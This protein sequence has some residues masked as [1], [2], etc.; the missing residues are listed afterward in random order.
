MAEFNNSD[1]YYNNQNKTFDLN[2]RTLRNNNGTFDNRGGTFLGWGDIYSIDGTFNNE[3]GDFDA[4]ETTIGMLGG[5]FSN[6]NGGFFY[7]FGS[8]SVNYALPLFF[9]NWGG[10]FDNSGG[11]TYLSDYSLFKNSFGAT[12]INSSIGHD[13]SSSASSGFFDTPG[14]YLSYSRFINESDSEFNNS[15]G[16]LSLYISTFENS[17]TFINSGG[18]LLQGGLSHTGGWT[19]MDGRT[20]RPVPVKPTGFYNSGIF[21]N[22]NGFVE[23]YG[24]FDNQ[25]G[26][27]NNTNG[28]FNGNFSNGSGTF[29]NANGR[30]DGSFSNGDGT[31]KG[32]GKFVVNN[33]SIQSGLFQ[34]EEMM[35]E[36]KFTLNNTGELEFLD[37]G[38]TP[39]LSVTKDVALKGGTISFGDLSTLTEGEFT[40]IDVTTN[41][42]LTIDTALMNEAAAVVDS[43]DTTSQ[44]F[45]LVQQN[46][47]LILT[48][49]H[50]DSV[51]LTGT[52]GN[53]ILTGTS[54]DEILNALDGDDILRGRGGNDVL[55]GGLGRDTYYGGNGADTFV[56]TEAD[57]VEGLG[58]TTG[59]VI[60]DFNANAGDVIQFDLGSSS[61]DRPHLYFDSA[62][63]NLLLVVSWGSGAAGFHVATLEGVSNFD[64]NTVEIV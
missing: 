46:N 58:Q 8:S 14:L 37:P 20:G 53:D 60:K 24:I 49:D 28:T 57:I 5:T 62:N 29:D 43:F 63:S 44:N 50:L 22:S 64:V 7:N 59:N 33:L 52:S 41:S 1:S 25:G 6:A 11:T 39:L 34:P 4:R 18:E 47:D 61:G 21:D 54:S 15:N 13:G 42:S 2:D 51:T 26:T 40:L 38:N 45:E 27:F 23:A 48:V 36:G 3:G 17:G 12:F 16:L 30:F 31:L 35:I 19:V 32:A 9:T 55:K 56:F 10:T